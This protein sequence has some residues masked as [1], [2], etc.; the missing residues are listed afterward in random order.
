MYD[1]SGLRA[2]GTRVVLD[3]WKMLVDHMKV[4]RDPADKAYMRHAGK[5]LVAVWGIGFS[6]GRRYTL[7]ECERLEK[8]GSHSQEVRDLLASSKAQLAMLLVDLEKAGKPR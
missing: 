7:E 3:D 2:G 8:R 4:G 1:L 6:D 5:P